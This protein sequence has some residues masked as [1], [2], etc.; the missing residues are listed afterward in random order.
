MCLHGVHGQHRCTAAMHN[1][2]NPIYARKI[3]DAVK[4]SPI[5]MITNIYVS[6]CKIKNHVVRVSFSWHKRY[7]I[8]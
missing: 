1:F 2:Q 6:H 7:L 4:Q 8:K 5:A 3:C